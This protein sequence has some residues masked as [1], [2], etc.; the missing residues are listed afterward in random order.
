MQNSKSKSSTTEL[1]E[2]MT[3]NFSES[4][5]PI[6]SQLINN[7]PWL[8][9]KDICEVLDLTHITNAIQTLDEDEK[10]TV[11]ILQSGQNRNMILVNESG[12]YALIMRSNKPQAKVFRKWVTSEVL[13]SIRKTG[14][15]VAPVKKNLDCDIDARDILY[16]TT[17]MDGHRVRQIEIEDVLYTCLDDAHKA[18]K[19]TRCSRGTA[20]ALNRRAKM[21]YKIWIYGLSH[22]SWWVTDRA[23]QLIR[24]A[25]R[26]PRANEQLTINI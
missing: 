11:K 7:E 24:C 16:H 20:L 19:G 5:S 26:S 12:M 10:L 23:I 4:Q 6:R 15:Y 1:N 22:P 18:I 25:A 8:V 17:Q 14:G 2:L 3:F 9:A 21:A 13:P